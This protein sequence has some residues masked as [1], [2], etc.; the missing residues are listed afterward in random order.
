MRVWQSIGSDRAKRKMLEEGA[1]ARA[2]DCPR[3]YEE[4]KW[5]C[6]RTNPL[7]DGRNDAVHAPYIVVLE[8]RKIIAKPRMH[9]YS[10]RA[11]NFGNSDSAAVL[12]ELSM[13]ILGM[14][15]FV[16]ALR[17]LSTAERDDPRWPERPTYLE[18]KKKQ[19]A[20]GNG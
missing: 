11:L 2:D 20:G 16:K 4:I 5:A 15:K 10:P 6:D 18:S 13:K 7:E 3:F 12:E 19:K 17:G 9:T 14:R 1:A 8:E